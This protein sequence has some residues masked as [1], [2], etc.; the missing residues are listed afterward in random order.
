MSAHYLDTLFAQI[1]QSLKS[2]CFSYFNARAADLN[3]LFSNP[4]A[5]QTI[6]PHVDHLATRTFFHS[7]DEAESARKV[8]LFQL[9]KEG[10]SLKQEIRYSSW[11]WTCIYGHG[12]S[13]MPEEDYQ[14]HI[15]NAKQGKP[16]SFAS[17]FSTYYILDQ[18]PD[19]S[20]SKHITRF[21]TKDLFPFLNDPY[22][23]IDVKAI[24]LHNANGQAN[25]LA[26]TTSNILL[27]QEF[28]APYSVQYTLNDLQI[29]EALNQQ[30]TWD[31]GNDYIELVER[32]E[33]NGLIKRHE[34]KVENT[35]PLFR[36][37]ALG[38]LRTY[39]TLAEKKNILVDR[40][41]LTEAFPDA[42]ESIDFLVNHQLLPLD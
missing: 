38:V 2:A 12:V 23:P 29:G 28:L 10:Y 18:I 17:L 42:T 4:D 27:A 8:E 33:I 36:S 21:N 40:E 15:S 41:H 35:E 16:S 9:E 6:T 13:D 22:I 26:L 32:H 5:K 34:F 19:I 3:A 39:T 1:P 14:L 30:S 11:K 37:T 31:L 7:P 20:L 25:H 24:V